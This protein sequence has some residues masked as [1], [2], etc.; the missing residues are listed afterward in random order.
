MK[1]ASANLR[2]GAGVKFKVVA[3]AAQGTQLELLGESGT[4][5]GRW[6]KVKLATG[7]EGWVA[8]SA[9]SDR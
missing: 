3:K 5:E 6:Y 4:A 7:E 9:V 1:V 2:D 8:A